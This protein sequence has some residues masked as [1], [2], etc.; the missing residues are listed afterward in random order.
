VVTAHS[1][2]STPHCCGSENVWEKMMLPALSLSGCNFAGHGDRQR[3]SRDQKINS[4]T[5]VGPLAATQKSGKRSLV[6]RIYVHA[7]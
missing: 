4:F 3:S 1:N 5:K 7:M 6:N 2:E